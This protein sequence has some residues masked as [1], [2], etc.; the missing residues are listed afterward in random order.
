[1]F[2][3][4]AQ[5]WAIPGWVVLG[6]AFSVE[7][8]DWWHRIEFVRAK[9]IEV[10]PFLQPTFD[11]MI[12][13]QGRLLIM[14]LGFVLLFLALFRKQP[15]QSHSVLDRKSEPVSTPKEPVAAS[16]QPAPAPP[17]T[18]SGGRE[19]VDVEPDYLMDMFAQHTSIQ[20]QRLI[21]PYIGKWMKVSGTLSDVQDTQYFSVVT[22]EN[23]PLAKLRIIFMYFEQPDRRDRLSVIRRGAPLTVL[24][25]IKKVTGFQIELWS[26][27]LI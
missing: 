15:L 12:S 21:E 10:A 19:T 24:G 1:M 18:T 20:A 6:F 25:Q 23:P 2:K 7:L 13:G 8:V 17:L 26:C 3:R 22:F 5:K 11:W 14:L 27:E 9:V 4:L 16:E